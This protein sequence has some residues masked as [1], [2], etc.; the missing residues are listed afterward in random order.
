MSVNPNKSF[1]YHFKTNIF[2]VLLS[3]GSLI[4]HAEA[5]RHGIDKDRT[6]YIQPLGNVDSESLK[7]LKK[8]SRRFLWI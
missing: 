1:V 5:I 4:C 6:I 8:I 7:Y 2:L 3:F